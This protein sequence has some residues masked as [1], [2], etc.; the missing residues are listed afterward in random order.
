MD[1]EWSVARTEEMNRGRQRVRECHVIVRPTG[2]RDVAL[3][4]VVEGPDGDLYGAVS[5]R[6]RGRREH[7][8]FQ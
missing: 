6:G 5:S 1:L 2:L 7:R 3:W 8:V 4:N